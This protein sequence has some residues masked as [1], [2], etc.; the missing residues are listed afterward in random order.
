ML[1]PLHTN[2][3]ASAITRL[4]EMGVEPFLT[5]SALDRVVAQRLAR[6]LCVHCKAPHVLSADYLEKV[7]YPVGVDLE[8]YEPKDA[9]AAPTPA[10]RAASA[11]TR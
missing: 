6:T 2:D 11:S 8:V 4:T 3:A 5:A 10:T 7:G 9:P 1:S